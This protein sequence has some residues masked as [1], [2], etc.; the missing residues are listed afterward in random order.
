M[1]KLR[2]EPWSDFVNWPPHPDTTHLSGT[3]CTV[4]KL[5]NFTIFTFFRPF[6][7]GSSGKLAEACRRIL[8]HPG[9]DRE[10]RRWAC[11]GLVSHS[12]KI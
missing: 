1:I 9:K 6:A 3:Y 4:W 2:S 12:V 8:I 11:E 7:D 10:M 5:Q